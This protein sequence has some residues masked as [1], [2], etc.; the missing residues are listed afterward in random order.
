MCILVS[1]EKPDGEWQVCET[2]AELAAAIG[3]SSSTLVSAVSEMFPW[4]DEDCLCPLHPKRT[5]KKLGLRLAR[6]YTARAKFV[7]DYA[8]KQPNAQGERRT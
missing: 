8:F 1:V 2:K 3:V 4:N 5:A 6:G 7:G